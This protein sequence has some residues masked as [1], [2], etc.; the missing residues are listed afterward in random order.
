M[1]RITDRREQAN[2]EVRTLKQV[3]PAEEAHQKWPQ[4]VPNDRHQHKNGPQ[5]VDHGGDRGQKLCKKGDRR[6]QRSRTKF[7]QKDRDTQR[8]R[9]SKDQSQNRCL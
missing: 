6:P 7:R 5:T 2:A 9:D 8:Q 4:L 3:S 1:A